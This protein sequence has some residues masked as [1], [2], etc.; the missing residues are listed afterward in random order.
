M[1]CASISFTLSTHKNE[2]ETAIKDGVEQ[3]RHVFGGE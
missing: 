1:F 3:R 2:I